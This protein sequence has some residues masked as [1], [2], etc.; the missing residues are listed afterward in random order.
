[1]RTT[2][3][4][5][6]NNIMLKK[7]AVLGTIF[8]MSIAMTGCG[9]KNVEGKLSDLMDKLYANFSEDELPMFLDQIEVTEENVE[10]FLGSKDIEFKEALASESMT[11]SIAYSVVLVRTKEGADVEKVKKQIKEN[12][13]PRKWICVGVEDEDVVI[14]NK[15]DLIIVIIVGDADHVSKLQ[16]EFRNLK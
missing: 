3:N 5:E 13:D 8:V 1:M 6:E 4:V 14:E 11:G 16:K 2:K 9:S 15:G 10:G 12:V 7:L